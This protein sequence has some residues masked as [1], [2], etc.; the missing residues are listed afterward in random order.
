MIQEKKTF[1]LSTEE[2]SVA[3][4]LCGYEQAAADAL[5]N[6]RD[7]ESDGQLQEVVGEAELL[8]R[9]RGYQNEK[10]EMDYGLESLI[11]L[12]MGAEKKVRC[13]HGKTVMLLHNMGSRKVL[14]QKCEDGIHSFYDMDMT[15]NKQGEKTIQDFYQFP[16][17]QLIETEPF[18]MSSEM[19]QSFSV[20]KTA[21]QVNELLSEGE[22]PPAMQAFMDAFVESGCFL[23]NLSLI[24]SDYITD[25]N[26]MPEIHLFLPSKSFIW[27]IDYT[28]VD[29]EGKVYF[30][31]T[32]ASSLIQMI[33]NRIKM[34]FGF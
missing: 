9:R 5:K 26:E 29:T 33:M 7:W 14:V 34:W 28:E 27:Y 8:L 1:S 6:T 32:E 21:K 13:V 2:L 11:H 12:L 20:A 15:K 31:P 23:N 25:E 4:M 22:H 3:M 16:A 19:F 17:E 18:I 10:G 30:Y 24:K